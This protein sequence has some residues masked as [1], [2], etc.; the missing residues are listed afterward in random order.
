[1]SCLFP[2]LL[3]CSSLMPALLSASGAQGGEYSD[4]TEIVCG[5]LYNFPH[6]ML[7]TVRGP[8][9]ISQCQRAAL[10]LQERER[11][12]INLELLLS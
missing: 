9:L 1:M 3:S 11:S 5:L 12:R 8:S 10:E 4:C 2:C 7:C 6:K